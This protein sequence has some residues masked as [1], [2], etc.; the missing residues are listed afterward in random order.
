MSELIN[1]DSPSNLQKTIGFAMISGE[2]ENLIRLDSL[3]IRSGIWWQFLNFYFFEIYPF[4]KAM[5]FKKKTLWSLFIDGVQLPRLEPLR[6]GS[7]L[8][9]TKF[10]EITGTH[11]IDLGRM[12]G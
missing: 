6:G 2:I 7:L 12:K 1:F 8:F 9:T 5:T 3:N 10:P 4:H 11:F